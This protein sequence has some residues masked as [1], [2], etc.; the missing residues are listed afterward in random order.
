MAAT[1][2]V[3][4][5][6]TEAGIVTEAE[7]VTA[8]AGTNRNDLGDETHLHALKASCIS[9]AAAGACY[10]VVTYPVAS[11]QA[12]AGAAEGAGLVKVAQC[13][14][15]HGVVKL[16]GGVSRQMVPGIV[17]GALTFGVY[18]TLLRWAS[19]PD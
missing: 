1:G 10:H 13:A 5:T 12:L 16:F 17:T 14:R 6:G 9:G 4:E 2:A 15:D 7:I 19:R 3:T 8:V 18:D 11:A